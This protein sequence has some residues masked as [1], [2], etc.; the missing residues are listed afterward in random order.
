MRQPAYDQLVA[1][2]RRASRNAVDAEDLL[3]DALIA[4]LAAGRQDVSEPGN[5]RWLYGVIRNGT[6]MRHRSAT[7][8]R[9]REAEWGTHRADAAPAPAQP[10]IDAWLSALTPALK[11]VAVLALTGH[12]RREIAY[13]LG[14]TD[15]AL[16][17]RVV[18]LRRRLADLGVAMPPGIPGLGLDL[19]YGRIRAALLPLL[20]RRNGLFASHD[21]DGHL[22]VVSRSQNRPPRQQGA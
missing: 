2:A 20:L 3:Q 10:A 4:A 11:P 22:F 13:L 8:R 6:R 9:R 17:Q 19:A 14:L 1:L 7:R 16:R 15:T 21:P 18:A 5:R 12:D